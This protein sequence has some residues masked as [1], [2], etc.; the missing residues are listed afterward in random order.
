MQRHICNFKNK[1]HNGCAQ[2]AINRR[3]MS[4]LPLTSKLRAIP[5]YIDSR[6]LNQPDRYVRDILDNTPKSLE[7]V[8]IEPN[9]RWTTKSADADHFPSS[10]STVFGA[11][12]EIEISDVAVVG[13]GRSYD[14]PK[15]SVTA[16]GTPVSAP[17]GGSSS[18]PRAT[19]STSAKRPATEVIDLTLSSDEDDEPVQR[20]TKRQNTANGYSDSLGFLSESPLGFP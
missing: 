7:T 3:R 20:P 4:I 11:D 2:F 1:D 17:R 16:L 6:V 13:G 10:N 5:L 15:Q 14:T 12:D 8:T 19:G 9:G 18:T